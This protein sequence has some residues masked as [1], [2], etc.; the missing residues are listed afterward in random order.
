[1]FDE[2]GLK[3][4]LISVRAAGWAPPPDPASLASLVRAMLAHVGAVDPELRDDLIF[5]A[6]RRWIMDGVLGDEALRDVLSTALDEAHLGK[7]AGSPEGDDVYTRSFSA[8]VAALVLERDRA[9]P[10][11]DG[12]ETRFVEDRLL[13]CF[14]RERNLSGYV[15][16]KGW[17]H[18]VAHFA[19]TFEAL[20]YSPHVGADDAER[21]LGAIGAKAKTERGYLLFGEDERLA[22]AAAVYLR[23]RLLG[24]DRVARWLD[25]VADL[26]KTGALPADL[27][28]L[29]NARNFL[30]SLYFKIKGEPGLEAVVAALTK[31]VEEAAFT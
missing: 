10:F 28:A 22:E 16:D 4:A 12:A 14:G 11:L 15:P 1:M 27:V 6:F 5:R 17:A 18:A 24:D 2:A 29:F 31:H 7:G 9:R 25:V 26:P 30:R 20:G 13:E 21:V 23:R 3:A 8:L 19:D